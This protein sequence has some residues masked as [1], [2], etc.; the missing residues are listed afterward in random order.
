MPGGVT[1]L[2]LMQLVISP[3]KSTLVILNAL[4]LFL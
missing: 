2:S 1:R 4:Q 3:L